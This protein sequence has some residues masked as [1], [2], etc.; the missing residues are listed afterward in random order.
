MVDWA[1]EF[2]APPNPIAQNSAIKLFKKRGNFNQLQMH[3]QMQKMDQTRSLVMASYRN[4]R[5]KQM[6]DNQVPDLSGE[7]D[8]DFIDLQDYKFRYGEQIDVLRRKTE[9]V[10]HG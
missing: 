9:S 8:I 10:D 7:I 1:K 5:L 2:K 3:N 4:S 6:L